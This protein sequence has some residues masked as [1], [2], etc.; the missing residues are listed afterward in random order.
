MTHLSLFSGIGG[1]DLAAHWAGYSTIALVERDEYCQ[2]VLAKNFPGVPIYD[3]VTTFNGEPFLGRVTLLS[4]GSPCQ[5][6]STANRTG[7]GVDGERSGLY[8][9]IIRIATECRPNWVLIEN[10]HQ[11]IHRGLDRVLSDLEGIGYRATTIVLSSASTG[12]THKRKRIWVVAHSDQDEQFA[13]PINDEAPMLSEFQRHLWRNLGAVDV[14]THDGIPRGLDKYRRRRLE[15]LGNAVSPTQAFPILQAIAD[16]T[17]P[18][19]Q[20]DI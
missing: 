14:R 13:L 20:V 7:K 17:N 10:V 19:P 12:A 3:D 6:I 5:D 18:P 16:L 9:E 15:A 11:L 2:K 1:I 4:G 8:R